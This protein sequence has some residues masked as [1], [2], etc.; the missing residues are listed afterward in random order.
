M[1]LITRREKE[2]LHHLCQG[3]T[4]KEVARECYISTYTVDSHRKNLYE[5][6]QAKT[7]IELGVKAVSLGL[8]SF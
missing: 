2:I 6:L 7:G 3:L 8:I 5:K 1:L 4:S